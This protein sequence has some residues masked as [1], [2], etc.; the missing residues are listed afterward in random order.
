MAMQWGSSGDI[1]AAG[2]YDGDNRED[3]AVYRPSTGEWYI[4]QSSNSAA[5]IRRYGAKGDLPAPTYDKP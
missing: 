4:S 1:P 5:L 3:L 2:D